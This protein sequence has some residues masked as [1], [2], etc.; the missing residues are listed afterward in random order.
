[1]L[2]CKWVE[3]KRSTLLKYIIRGP[4]LWNDRTELREE[5]GASPNH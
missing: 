5:M 4:L 3:I 1:M 2:V